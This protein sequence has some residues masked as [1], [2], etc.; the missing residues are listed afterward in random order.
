MVIINDPVINYNILIKILIDKGIE[1]Y[2]SIEDL[3]QP[4]HMP[5]KS[6]ENTIDTNIVKLFLKKLYNE[7]GIE[8]GTIV[9]AITNNFVNQEDKIR[10]ERKIQHLAFTFIY[11]GAG[12]NLYSDIHSDTVSMVIIKKI[13]DLPNED[14][15]V[16]EKK[17]YDW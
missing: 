15:P 17:I 13:N 2:N 10:L 1:V 12:L 8:T 9:S 4:V 5:I 7:K 11:P 6:Y 3:P 14:S 16:S